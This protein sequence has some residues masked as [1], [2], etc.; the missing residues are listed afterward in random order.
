MDIWDKLER[1]KSIIIWI[2]VYL[3]STVLIYLLAISPLFSYAY[4]TTHINPITFGICV[5][6]FLI[7]VHLLPIKTDRPSSYLFYLIYIVAYLPTLLYTWMNN[8]EVRYI[9]YF[10]F[11]IIIIEVFVS[12]SHV[13]C[14]GI[15]NAEVFFYGFFV[16]YVFASF[17]LVILNGGI[18]PNSFLI[19][20][21]SANRNNNVSGFWGYL[22]NWCAKSFSPIYFAFFYYK[23]KWRLVGFVCVIQILLYLS[24]GFKAFLFSIGLLIFMTFILEKGMHYFKLMP[25][26]FSFVHVLSYLLFKTGITQLPLFTFAYR[27]LFIPAQC[28]F[29]YYEFFTNND[30]LHFSEGIIG[31]IFGVNYPYTY[32]IGVIVNQYTFGKDYYSNGNTGM[33][34]YG[35]ADFG[36][37]GMVLASIL[38]VII[39]KIVDGSTLNIPKSLVV[40]AMSYQMI[41]LNDSNLLIS[42]NTG[43][44]IFSIFLLI[45]IN[46][47]QIINDKDED[48]K[49]LGL[50]LE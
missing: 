21:I 50:L 33:F 44:I 5:L 20:E 19:S 34:S 43:G 9:L 40:S 48:D 26:L 35:F 28:Q 12:S 14:I 37:L 29:Q 31:K 38:L 45:V 47:N 15:K 23:R 30:F 2:V 4:M 49:V 42:L 3:L 36:F 17:L 25:E 24:F 7:T 22:L 39:F 46:S 27:T 11:C 16:I 8:M 13:I 10:T 41:I 1:K 18:N 6:L 32:P